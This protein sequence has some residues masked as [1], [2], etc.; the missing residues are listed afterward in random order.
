MRSAGSLGASVRATASLVGIVAILVGVPIL[1]W[2][3]GTPL[4][5]S[6]VP[7]LHEAMAVFLRPDDGSLLMGTLLVIG[8]LVWAQLS[9][10]D[11]RRTGRG[12]APPPGTAG[13][14]ARA[15]GE[16]AARVR[17]RRRC[18]RRGRHRACPGGRSRSPPSWPPTTG[19]PTIRPPTR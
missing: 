3:L 18:A 2:Q 12:A 17:P 19:P 7:S 6:R 8:V 10:V 9:A 1:L 11:P 5:P 16:Q 13:R 4:L 14:A 15:G